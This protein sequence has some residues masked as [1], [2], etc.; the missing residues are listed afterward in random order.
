MRVLKSE[1]WPKAGVW[2]VVV[3]L[4]LLAGFIRWSDPVA[5]AV[6]G[7]T[8]SP[9]EWIHEMTAILKNLNKK[10]KPT[11]RTKL[12]FRANL[13]F[14]SEGAIRHV[15]L[16]TLKKKVDA[17]K[18]AGVSGIDVNVGLFPWLE[19]HALTVGKC[20]DLFAYIRDQGL[21]L[22]LNPIYTP[23]HHKVIDF[24]DFR[25][26]A[27]KVWVEIAR[28]YKPEILVVCH[29]PT[30]QATRMGFAVNPAEWAEFV[31]DMAGKI[32]AVSP[33]TRLGAG[34][35]PTEYEY[36]K[37]F[38]KIPELTYI[39]FDIYGL[40]YLKGVNRMIKEAKQAG[41]IVYVEETWRPPYF[42]GEITNIDTLM[43]ESI[44]SSRFQEI[45]RLWLEFI[46]LYASTLQ[47]EC[48]TPFWTQA[49]FKYV[50]VHPGDNALDPRYKLEV[51]SAINN[52][53][54]TRTYT[55]FRELIRAHGEKK[56]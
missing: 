47:L 41:K 10:L 34:L 19:N 36:F 13:F 1:I 21:T 39:S 22:T 4:L 44:G 12:T 37:E 32:R 25:V 2:L 48:V 55:R 56:D 53:E 15:P 54:R 29:E 33:A 51:I 52:R 6:E 11:A 7:V 31:R 18:L 45:D 24:N 9:D 35:W 20:D 14:A 26:K 28:R 17:F 49:F 27:E 30:T 50:D 5:H 23:V 38:I 46:T 40:R 42:T 16:E 8:M 3:G 43:A